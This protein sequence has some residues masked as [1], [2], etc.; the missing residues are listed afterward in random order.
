MSQGFFPIFWKFL[1]FRAF[2]AYRNR[3]TSFLD[4]HIHN[5]GLFKPGGFSSAASTG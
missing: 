4:R 5:A 3:G 1:K 2:Q